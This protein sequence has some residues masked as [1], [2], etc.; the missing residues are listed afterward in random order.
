LS[1]E[2]DHGKHRLASLGL[3]HEARTDKALLLESIFFLVVEAGAWPLV[4]LLQA[5][6]T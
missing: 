6:Q 2:N 4:M 5:N 3:A 1:G